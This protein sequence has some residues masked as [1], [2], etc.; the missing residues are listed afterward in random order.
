MRLIL[1]AFALC[2]T[3]AR[4]DDDVVRFHGYAY[5]LDSGRHAFT[6]VFEPRLADGRWTGNG[7]VSYYL[8]DGRELGRK[9]LDFGTDDF[10]P[11]YRLELK[12][13]YAEAITAIGDA[14]EMSR[15]TAA[16]TERQSVKKDV[17]TAADAGLPRLLRAH[18]P[19][20]ARGET[21][22]FQVVAPIRLAAY[23]FRATRTD[24]TTFEGK[25]ALRVQVDMDSML[26]LFAGPL[27]FTFDPETEK[28][29]EFRGSTNVLD[30]ATGAP[31]KVRIAYFSKPPARA[32]VL[33]P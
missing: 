19:Q 29:L 17:L 18:L 26:K 8:P 12:H 32:P 6:E 21:V 25:P 27:L 4:A 10:V 7:V 1:L 31:F 2:A 33:P 24:E 22:K 5:H 13:G 15:T 23:R 30:P 14:I 11:L 9:T 16:R 3:A 20:L 28:L